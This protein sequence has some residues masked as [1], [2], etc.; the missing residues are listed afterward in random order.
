M[1]GKFDGFPQSGLLE[2]HVRTENLA[3][4]ARTL[5]QPVCD[6]GTWQVGLKHPQ[7]YYRYK[8]SM[9]VVYDGL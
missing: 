5:N 7:Y 2:P 4:L 8:V 1:I 6:I 3:D 9:Q